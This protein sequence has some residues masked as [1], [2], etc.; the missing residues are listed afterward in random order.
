VGGHQTD[1]ASSPLH[2]LLSNPQVSRP[3]N[4]VVFLQSC[5]VDSRVVVQQDGRARNLRH[6]HPLNHAGAPQPSQAVR[7]R[8]NQAHIHQYNLAYCL[9]RRLVLSRHQYRRCSRKVVQLVSHHS[10]LP[11]NRVNS[12]PHSPRYSQLDTPLRSLHIRRPCSR[13]RAQRHS[14]AVS[15]VLCRRYSRP[16]V[17]VH[18][19]A[20]CHRCSLP[21]GPAVSPADCRAVSLLSCLA[22]SHLRDRPCSLQRLRRNSRQTIQLRNR[23]VNR[24]P[25]RV[26]VQAHN[27]QAVLPKD[28]ATSPPRNR[29]DPLRCNQALDLLHSH[30]ARQRAS[31]Q[32]SPVVIRAHNLVLDLAVNQ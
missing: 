22:C 25:S 5:R 13:A 28:L 26:L 4:P 12:P 32:C 24:Q 19:R 31:L 3:L 15:R 2:N 8:L 10:D 11:V 21:A 20:R 23:R 17:R 16:Q 7:H 6:G 9:L 1:P 14:L 27:Q 30:R 18:N 29:V